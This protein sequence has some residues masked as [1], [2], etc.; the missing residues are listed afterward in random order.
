MREAGDR[1]QLF[2]P[3]TEPRVNATDGDRAGPERTPQGGE[4]RVQHHLTFFFAFGPNAGSG[5]GSLGLPARSV[6]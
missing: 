3:V 1:R 5:G 2:L 6:R 4:S